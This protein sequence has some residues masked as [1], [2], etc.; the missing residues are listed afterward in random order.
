MVIAYGMSQIAII[1][2]TTA[3]MLVCTV[4]AKTVLELCYRN[5][6]YPEQWLVDL[7]LGLL[8][9]TV[10]FWLVFSCLAL[11]L[12][13]I[14]EVAVRLFWRDQTGG[15]KVSQSDSD[16]PPPKKISDFASAEEMYHYKGDIISPNWPTPL[17]S[18]SRAAED[19]KKLGNPAVQIFD[20]IDGN[21]DGVSVPHGTSAVAVDRSI[22][23]WVKNITVRSPKEPK[24]S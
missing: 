12:W 9:N 24:K 19:A 23:T 10:A 14:L 2:A 16:R 8:N 13:L 15:S 18:P 11:V 4:L 17:R 22:R 1:I 5:G 3:R 7:T 20:S 21:V 6:F